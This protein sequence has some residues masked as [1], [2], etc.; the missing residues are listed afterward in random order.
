MTTVEIERSRI[1]H[2]VLRYWTR[3]M[4]RINTPS[5]LGIHYEGRVLWDHVEDRPVV[6]TWK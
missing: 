2:R 4:V 1:D 6:K 5:R 3:A